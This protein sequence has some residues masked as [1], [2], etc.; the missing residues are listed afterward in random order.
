MFSAIRVECVVGLESNALACGVK[1][2]GAILAAGALVL[3]L[4]SAS[5]AQAQ[6]TGSGALAPSSGTDQ[7][8]AM[9]VAG[10]SA[11]VSALVTSINSVNTAF[12]TQSSA[13]IGSPAILSPTRRVAASG[14]AAWAV[15]SVPAQPPQ[16]E[17]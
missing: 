4:L 15:T 9:A 11:S 5:G 14:P 6:C 17:T 13:F 12:L 3:T 16:P 10:V 7:T 2:K 1:R 8:V